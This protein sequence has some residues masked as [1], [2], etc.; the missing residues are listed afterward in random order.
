MR[1]LYSLGI[2]AL[3]AV[4]AACTTTQGG[5]TPSRPAV[6]ILVPAFGATFLE[7]Q[8]V[9]IQSVSTD[10]TGI[11]R[12]ELS[13]D[14]QPV[15]TDQAVTQGQ[16]QFNV[17]QVW[18]AQ[19]VGAH[20]VLVR[21]F[22][23]ANVSAEASIPIAVSAAIA[24][25]PT[26]TQAPIVIVV[27]ATPPQPTDAP[28]VFV[29]PFPATQT[30]L[31]PTLPPPTPI[32]PTPIP[33]TLPPLV[34]LPPFDGGMNVVV[35]WDGEQMQLEATANDTLVGGDDGDGIA[36][37][38]FFIQDLQGNVIAT[39]RENNKPYCFFGESDGQ[40]TFGR[41]GE[42]NFR[43]SPDK[44]IQSGW[45][46]IRAVAH[47]RDNRIQVAERPLYVNLGDA[48][49]ESL[50]V[51]LTEP[52]NF[53]LEKELTIRAETDGPSSNS[54]IDHVDFFVVT[55]DS[56]IVHKR[57]EQSADYCGF[58]GGENNQP[59][60]TYNFKQNGLKWL[61]GDPVFPTQYIVR[62]IAYARDGAIAAN[63][64]FF[65]IDRVQ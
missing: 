49:P 56:K 11:T 2:L 9:G 45:Y 31:P 58:G 18:T 41:Q 20:A 19:G 60:N 16:T 62:A 27:T 40:C 7:G 32:P 34:F 54:G 23:T 1:L 38:E 43:W 37:I 36:Y 28:I 46:F 50:F 5:V 53:N 48:P 55:Y 24:D 33:P 21:A 47:T 4:C 63:T 42:P 59:C 44:P 51:N 39:K 35:D 10:P 8:P 22:N 64:V 61:N 3:V 17:V 13:I 12:V 65:Q 57:T 15:K 14:G 6:Q 29:P 25:L 52:S 26:A 30:A